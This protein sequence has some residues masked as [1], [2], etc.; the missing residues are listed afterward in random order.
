MFLALHVVQLDVL[1]LLE[2]L[3][4]LLGSRWWYGEQLVDHNPVLSVSPLDLEEYAEVLLARYLDSCGY[5]TLNIH[6]VC[7][8]GSQSHYSYCN[9]HIDSAIWDLCVMRMVSI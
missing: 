2:F 7:L 4:P 8:R 9:C 3:L 5:M 1:E 6:L